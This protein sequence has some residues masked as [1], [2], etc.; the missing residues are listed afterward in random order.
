MFQ[1]IFVAVIVVLLCAVVIGLLRI[2]KSV[3]TLSRTA[4][5]FLARHEAKEDAIVEGGAKYDSPESAE[6]PVRRAS[7]RWQ[8]TEGQFYYLT[9]R[10]GQCGAELNRVQEVWCNP[11]YPIGYCS[12]ECAEPSR[13]ARQN[14]RISRI[15]GRAA[16]KALLMSLGV[17]EHE[18]DES[19]RKSDELL[20]E[21]RFKKYERLQRP[22]GEASRPE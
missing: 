18:I 12:R 9:D 7:A 3:D 14:A 10:C 2:H 13:L 21:L 6:G 16:M 15:G 22:Q 17:K 1:T 4:S 19:Q 5:F 8:E 20:E 11:P